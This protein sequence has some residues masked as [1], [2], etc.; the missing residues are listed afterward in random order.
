MTDE[1]QQPRTYQQAW[2]D[3]EAHIKELASKS[4]MNNP[5]SPSR[6]LEKMQELR[7]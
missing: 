2:E 6:I 7:P 5:W 4:Y 1:D 3:L